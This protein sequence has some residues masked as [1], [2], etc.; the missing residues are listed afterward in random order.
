MTI[1]FSKIANIKGLNIKIN[2]TR[3]FYKNKEE[4]K[5]IKINMQILV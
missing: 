3:R 2:K 5:T 4:K 1:F